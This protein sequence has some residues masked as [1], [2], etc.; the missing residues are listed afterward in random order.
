LQFDDIWSKSRQRLDVH[1]TARISVRMLEEVGGNSDGPARGGGALTSNR[2]SAR[3]VAV[4]VVKNSQNARHIKSY[5]G[6]NEILF[7]ESLA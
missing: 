1:P 4:L 3:I 6:T 2:E 5:F 7:P